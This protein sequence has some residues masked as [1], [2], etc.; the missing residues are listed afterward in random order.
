M[1]NRVFVSLGSNINKETNLH[2]AV[3]LLQE[4]SRLL[5]VSSVYE[6]APIETAAEG[7]PVQKDGLLFWN[8]A[9]LMETILDPTGFRRDVLDQVERQLNRQRTADRD[10]PR[11]IDADLTLF[12]EE[13]FELDPGHLI[14]DPDLLKFA[15]VAVPVAELAPNLNHPES[16]EALG[17]IAERLLRE[18]AADNRP[19]P[20]RRPDIVLGA[21]GRT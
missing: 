8:A 2:T 10:A 14:P 9:V 20:L 3:K 18:A 16:G 21:K 5:A 17:Q 11:T 7:S 12:N 1:T 15:H 13:V 4:K 19:L 6:T